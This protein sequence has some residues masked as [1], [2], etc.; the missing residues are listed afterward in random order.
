MKGRTEEMNEVTRKVVK[1]MSWEEDGE[2]KD[3]K[4]RKCWTPNT[5]IK[6]G[7]KSHMQCRGRRGEGTSEMWVKKTI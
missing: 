2:T 7:G 4:D 6:R 5:G 1:S 3:G